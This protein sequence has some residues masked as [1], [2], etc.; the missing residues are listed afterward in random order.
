VAVVVV[1]VV[2]AVIAVVWWVLF[3]MQ[4]FTVVGGKF[5][6]WFICCEGEN[7]IACAVVNVGVVCRPE[8][9]SIVVMGAC[10]CICSCNCCCICCCCC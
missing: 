8:G 6:D 2:P 10:I 7:V 9:G 4:R 5:G 1:V 3:V